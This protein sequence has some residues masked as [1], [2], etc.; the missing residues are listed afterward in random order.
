M[1]SSGMPSTG[2]LSVRRDVVN[3]RHG[4]MQTEGNQ[5]DEPLDRERPDQREAGAGATV[6]LAREIG[7]ALISTSVLREGEE[8]FKA[9]TSNS[10]RM[11]SRRP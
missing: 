11:E 4:N 3:A 10:R 8:A 7:H 6:L 2:R 1:R 9:S 5:P